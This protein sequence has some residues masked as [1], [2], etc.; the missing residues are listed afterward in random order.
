MTTGR[1][2]LVLDLPHRPALGRDDFLVAPCNEAAVE[3]VDLWP[4][5]PGPALALCGPSGSGKTHLAAVWQS[6]TGA[7]RIEPGAISGALDDGK[8]PAKHLIIEDMVCPDHEE[9]LLH[10]YN[11]IAESGGSLLLTSE[12]PPARWPLKLA[13]LASRLRATPVAEIGAP[14]DALL[15]ALLVKMFADRQLR[16][17]PEVIAFLL[18]RMERSFAGARNLVERLDGA[19]LSQQ[20]TITIPLARTVFQEDEAQET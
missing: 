3:W 5:W 1:R 12:T 9:A 11:Q 6:R 20:R 16:V 17:G 2:Q 13:D 8:L 15:E 4:H 14:D 18:P 7:I 10:L 19:A